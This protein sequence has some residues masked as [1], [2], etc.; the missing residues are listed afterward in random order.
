MSLEISLA[1]TLNEKITIKRKINRLVLS[2]VYLQH[3]IFLDSSDNVLLM[4]F[5]KCTLCTQIHKFL[6]YR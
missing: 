2:F 4:N 3:K 1:V 5:I 6:S